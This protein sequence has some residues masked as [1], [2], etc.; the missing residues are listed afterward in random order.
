MK[1]EARN[2]SMQ[3]N[4]AGRVIEIFDQANVTVPAGGSLAIVGKS[5]VGKTTFLYILGGLETPTSGEVLVGDQSLSTLDDIS[6]FR[7]KNLGFIFQF[8]HLLPEFS[9]LEN[10]MMPLIILGQDRNSAQKRG[11]ELLERV[12]LEQRLEH[13]PGMLS[14]GEQQRVAI[15]RAFAAKPGVILA[16]EPTGNLDQQTGAEVI[17][18]LLKMHQ[19]EKMTLIVVTHS[20]E[21]ARMMSEVMELTPKGF[22]KK[23]L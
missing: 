1:V 15:A 2:L 5:G 21:L 8:H 9:A 20:F 6:Q 22:L 11:R 14:G 4:D 16:D 7:G 17:K 3:F 23:S 10:V 13:R 19:E 18:L 12:G